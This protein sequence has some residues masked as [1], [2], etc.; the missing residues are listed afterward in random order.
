MHPPGDDHAILRLISVLPARTPVGTLPARLGEL[1]RALTT[2]DT[3]D[4]AAI[5]DMIWTLWMHHPHRRAA[6][7]LER[8]TADIAAQRYDIAETRL[9]LLLRS[10]PDF[11][12]AWNKRATL[13]YILQRDDE[14]LA[15]IR[16]TLELEPRHFGALCGFAEICLGRGHPESALLAFR[17]A[18]RLNPHLKS[19][20]ESCQKIGQ[21]RYM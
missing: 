3:P 14:C 20:A 9:A 19:A 21:A 15:D 11:P 16:R 5:E 7:A 4:A 2:G 1:F 17:A 18:L 13:Y 6:E 12:E 8:A 10:R